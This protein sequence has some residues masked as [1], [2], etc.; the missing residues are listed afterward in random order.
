LAFQKSVFQTMLQSN[1]KPIVRASRPAVENKQPRKLVLALVLLVVALVGVLIKDRDFWFG[2]GE[3]S[4]ADVA[5]N[6]AQSAA[7]PQATRPVVTKQVPGAAQK[8]LPA[9]KQVVIAKPA[10][11]SKA[12]DIPAVATTRTPLAPLD[13]EVVAGDNHRTIRPGSNATKVEITNPGSR[14]QSAASFGGATT[15]AEREHLS[16]DVPTAQAYPLLTQHTNVEGSVVLQAVINASGV[17]ENLK[18]LSGPGIL[19]PAAQQ[20]VRE[21]HFKPIVQNG[22]AVESK[23][24]ITV[25]FSIKIADGNAKTTLAESRSENIQI[26]SR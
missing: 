11:E 10:T 3:S 18:V 12:A 25:N 2:D 16:L 22:Q 20:A 6:G 5:Q 15:A 17:I 7:Q 26:L 4:I 9:K 19:T 1:A 23:A 21:W 13:V 14:S 8:T 24:R